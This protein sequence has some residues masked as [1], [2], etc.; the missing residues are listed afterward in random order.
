MADAQ[1][2]ALLAY[3][4]QHFDQ[5]VPTGAPTAPSLRA[6]VRVMAAVLASEIAGREMPEPVAAQVVDYWKQLLERWTYEALS[7]R[8]PPR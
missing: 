2:G 5:I 6:M 7:Q 8:R 3:L 4:M 1:A